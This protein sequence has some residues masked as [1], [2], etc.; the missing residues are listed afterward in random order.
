MRLRGLECSIQSTSQ[1]PPRCTPE[2]RLRR[3]LLGPARRSLCATCRAERAFEQ[4]RQPRAPRQRAPTSSTHGRCVL[5]GQH[6]AGPCLAALCTPTTNELHVKVLS[7][8]CADT[9][10]KQTPAV[11]QARVCMRLPRLEILVRNPHLF[12]NIKLLSTPTPTYTAARCSFVRAKQRGIWHAQPATSAPFRLF[13]LSLIKSLCQ[14]PKHVVLACHSCSTSPHVPSQIPG[15][16]A[17]LSLGVYSSISTRSVRPTVPHR[18]CSHHLH[19]MQL[20]S[21]WFC[22]AAA[23]MENSSAA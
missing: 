13:I 14:C 3:S 20:G 19:H 21:S 1:G 10:P 7:A 6:P 17:P 18:R 5:I 16:R 22:Y 2:K 23:P 15:A 11:S 8:P 12:T 4:Q 9:F